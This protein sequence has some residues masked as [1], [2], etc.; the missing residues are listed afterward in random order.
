MARASRQIADSG[1]YHVV[2][3]GSGQQ[4]IFADDSDRVRFLELCCE[5]LHGGD[6]EVEVLAWCLMDNHVHILLRGEMGHISTALQNVCSR[7]ALYFNKKEGRSGHLFQDR[8]WSS[9][10]EDDAYL[11]EA[12][13]YIHANPEVAGLCR[14]EEHRWSSY[15]AYTR[16]LGSRLTETATVLD[17]VGGAEAFAS[18]SR[19]SPRLAYR[20]E[21][22]SRIPDCEAAS[23]AALA[24]GGTRTNEVKSLPV[25]ERSKALADL[26]SVGLSVRQIQRLTGVGRNAICMASA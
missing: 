15:A 2:M 20:F 25:G 1:I 22:G 13:R 19:E 14:L 5:L 7:Y 24:L 17:M 6:D 12:V 21:G 4:I 3:R 23:V 8:F 9:P 26:K 18:F 10:I 11:L 16:G